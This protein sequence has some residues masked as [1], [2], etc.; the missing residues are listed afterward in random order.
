M[1]VV[2]RV[3]HS[4]ILRILVRVSSYPGYF[5]WKSQ[6]TVLCFLNK[7]IFLT[8]SQIGARRKMSYVQLVRY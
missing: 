7:Q 5:S 6:E 8:D 2:S 3:E 1:G 4:E